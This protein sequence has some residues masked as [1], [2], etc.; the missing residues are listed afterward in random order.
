MQM[1][2]EGV[3]LP[4]NWPV[5][6]PGITSQAIIR[7][8][9]GSLQLLGTCPRASLRWMLLRGAALRRQLLCAVL[10]L[11]RGLFAACTM[12]TRCG[13][14]WMSEAQILLS[15]CLRVVYTRAGWDSDGLQSDSHC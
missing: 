6:S 4:R 13:N 10:G 1:P 12:V 2:V 7:T 5:A 11:F 9:E 15:N 8:P 14:L 3:R